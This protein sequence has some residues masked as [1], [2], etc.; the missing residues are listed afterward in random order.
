MSNLER[1]L[2]G[3][4]FSRHEI[5]AVAGRALVA[6]CHK[7]EGTTVFLLYGLAGGDYHKTSIYI[8][9]LCS[10]T[11]ILDRI[12]DE[13]LIVHGLTQRARTAL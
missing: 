8:M 11:G 6:P 7:T 2:V 3:S 4:K 5:Q 10:N 13:M 9:Q 1:L 12:L